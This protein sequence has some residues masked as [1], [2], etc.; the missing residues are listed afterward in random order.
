MVPIV[1][2]GSLSKISEHTVRS[3]DPMGNE[4][5]TSNY[6]FQIVLAQTHCFSV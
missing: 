1:T 2:L 5:G 3:M 6:I 4:S